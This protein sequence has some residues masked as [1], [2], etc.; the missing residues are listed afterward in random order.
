MTGRW[1][2]VTTPSGPRPEPSER[3]RRERTIT[4]DLPLRPDLVVRLS[5]PLDLTAADA[6]RVAGFVRSLVFEAGVTAEPHVV[7]AGGRLR[8]SK[9]TVPGAGGGLVDAPRIDCRTCQEAQVKQ[10]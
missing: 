10:R 7:V 6:E 5:L 9:H 4:Y 8:C 2:E 3:E 1:V